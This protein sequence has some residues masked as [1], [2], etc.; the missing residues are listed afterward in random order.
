MGWF[1]DGL[2]AVAERVNPWSVR[3]QA[4]SGGVSGGR[5]LGGGV[6]LDVSDAVNQFVGVGVGNAL[7]AVEACAG[8]W[9]SA[10]EHANVEVNGK[11]V[12]DE[13]LLGRL[14]Y[15]ISPRMMGQVGRALIMSGEIVYRK[16]TGSLGLYPEVYFVLA[17][18]HQVSGLANPMFWKYDVTLNSPNGT[19]ETG[20][21]A[22]ERYDNQPAMDVL[23]VMYAS[24]YDTPWVGMSPLL[25]A[26]QTLSL[27]KNVE[28]LL[29]DETSAKT[30]YIVLVPPSMEVELEDGSR[31]SSAG[32]VKESYLTASRRMAFF[33]GSD[34]GP[35]ESGLQR[36]LWRQ[37]RLGF[38]MED[39][40][41]AFRS[42]LRDDICA[43]CGVP[44]SLVASGQP[45][46]SI[47]EGMRQFSDNAVAPKLRVV[48]EELSK[49]IG[50]DVRSMPD[51]SHDIA[52]IGRAYGALTGKE[53][54][55]STDEASKFMGLRY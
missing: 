11:S 16:Y 7:A 30:G 18:N 36:D 10:F 44:V 26:K 4:A 46:A 41:R 23:H 51:L 21:I 29:Q 22:R 3:L 50:E 37:V 40:N 2:K 45:S 42:D 9:Q 53:D 52:S 5:S 28:G 54:P 6:P 20:G 47:R 55:M 34:P 8:L 13:V 1:R 31:M 24:H 38:L 12:F 35:G 15:E 39:S 25:G 27:M 17:Q 43:A 19:E 14:R 48:A 49:K 33:E 32:H